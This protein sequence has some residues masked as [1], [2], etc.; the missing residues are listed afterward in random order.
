MPDTRKCK[1]KPAVTTIAGFYHM[2]W[3]RTHIE[4]KETIVTVL[5]KP[6]WTGTARDALAGVRRELE[7][8]IKTDPSFE[9][10]HQP[11]NAGPGAPDVVRRMC[12]AAQRCGVGPMAAVAGA[13]AETAMRALVEAGAEECIIDNGGDVALFIREPVRVGIYAGASAHRNLAFE[14]AA[15]PGVFGICTSSGTVGH[16]CSY[17]RADAAV[18]LAT[19]VLLADASATALGNRIHS[20]QDLDTCFDWMRALPEIEGALVLYQE[21]IALWGNLPP[22]VRSHVDPDLITQGKGL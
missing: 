14:I 13:F 18:V 6:R 2:R 8:Y 17:G 9:K 4:Q 12:I 11:R 10:D 5:C 1:G 3:Q 20:R 19:D 21:H 15:R 16:S 22:I 7:E